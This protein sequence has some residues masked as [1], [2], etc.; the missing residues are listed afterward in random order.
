MKSVRSA[1]K[2]VGRDHRFRLMRESDASPQ[3]VRAS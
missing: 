1:V 2:R 3:L